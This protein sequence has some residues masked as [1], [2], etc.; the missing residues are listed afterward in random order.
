MKTTD[1]IKI[2]KNRGITLVEICIALLV[3]A[4][5][6]LPTIGTFSTFY[7][8]ASKQMEQEMGLKLAEAV[9]NKLNSV[10]YD[11]LLDKALGEMPIDIQAPDGTLTG[12]INFTESTGPAVMTGSCNN[13]QINKTKYLIDVEI[14][15]LF[16]GPTESMGNIT[17][18]NS[19]IYQYLGKNL[20]SDTLEK[21]TYICSDNMYL[22]NV[23]VKF[24]K[25]QPIT[26]SAFRADMVK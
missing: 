17:T 1:S 18:D 15:K 11:L 5:A 19:L 10:S 2:R 13:I 24:G 26:L 9:I 25:T 14:F 6:I 12:S 4:L 21:M 3:L 22:F 8:T 7:G 16:E 20:E 23:T